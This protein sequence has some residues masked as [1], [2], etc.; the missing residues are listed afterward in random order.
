MGGNS[1]TSVKHSLS[2]AG[3]TQHLSVE[4]LKSVP[5]SNALVASV[6]LARVYERGALPRRDAVTVSRVR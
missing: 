4:P 2:G 3:G 6:A 1:P 5:D